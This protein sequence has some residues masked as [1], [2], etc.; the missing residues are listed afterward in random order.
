[1]GGH[2]VSGRDRRGSAFYVNPQKGWRE[3]LRELAWNLDPLDYQR[4]EYKLARQVL[5]R[6]WLGGT[7]KPEPKS[8]PERNLQR[9]RYERVVKRIVVWER[10]ER[11]AK[12]AIRKLRKKKRY[13]EK[14]DPMTKAEQNK[15][16]RQVTIAVK[17]LEGAD[18]FARRKRT[19][20]IGP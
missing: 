3:F 12:N 20:R 11:R 15:I 4:L 6:G 9:D 5:K 2:R 19:A 10:K 8:E 18:P 13:Y 16:R 1:M 17:V 14:I 7:L